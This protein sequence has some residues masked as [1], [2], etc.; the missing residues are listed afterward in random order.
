MTGSGVI[1][2][3]VFDRMADYAVAKPSYDLIAA[4]PQRIMEKLAISSQAHSL[5]LPVSLPMGPKPKPKD[6]PVL[7]DPSGGLHI[8]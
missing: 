4:Q 8:H 1:R 5:R 6:A 7:R 2:R 3:F